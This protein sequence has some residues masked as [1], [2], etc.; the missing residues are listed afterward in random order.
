[1]A[2]IKKPSVYRVSVVQLGILLPVSLLLLLVS[3]TAALSAFLGGLLCVLP[4][5]YFTS[6]AFRYMGA[7]S[8]SMIA[9]S[10]YRGE[11]GKFLLSMVGF[12]AVFVL[13][14]PL[15]VLALFLAYIAM[16]LVQWIVTAR[17]VANRPPR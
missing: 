1:M 3:K 17:L 13:V 15:N 8:A 5:A 16:L 12:A 6:Y 7:R 10:F 14:K 4:H 2:S 11:S 9:R